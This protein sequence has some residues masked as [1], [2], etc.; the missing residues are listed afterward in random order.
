MKSFRNVAFALPPPP[1]IWEITMCDS[2]F[3]VG[4]AVRLKVMANLISYQTD[5]PQEGHASANVDNNGVELRISIFPTVRC[6]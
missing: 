4:E 3:G 1:N 6:E 5:L 2:E